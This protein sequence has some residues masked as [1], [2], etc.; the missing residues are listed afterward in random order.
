[1]VTEPE[2]WSPHATYEVTRLFTSNLK[3]GDVVK[4]F[5]LI[6]LDKVTADIYENKYG[7]E[8]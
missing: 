1:M 2:N 7:C 8:F 4:Y 3:T 5:E 6:L